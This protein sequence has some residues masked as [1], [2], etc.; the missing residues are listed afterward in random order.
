MD[1]QVRD[2]HLA[3]RH[4]HRLTDSARLPQARSGTTTPAITSFESDR[5]RSSYV[6]YGCLGDR[7]EVSD[8]VVEGALMAWWNALPL[9]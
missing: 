5:K 2:S 6:L 1:D 7:P 9:S 4:A 3:Q 8:S